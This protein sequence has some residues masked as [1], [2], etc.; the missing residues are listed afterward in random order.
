VDQDREDEMNYGK[1]GSQFFGFIPRLLFSSLYG[2]GFLL[3]A[4]DIEMTCLSGHSGMLP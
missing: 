3:N 2:V 1:G 4:G